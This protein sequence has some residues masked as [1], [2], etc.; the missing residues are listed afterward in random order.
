MKKRRLC[1]I[2]LICMMAGKI[3]AQQ[4]EKEYQINEVVISSLGIKKERKKIANAIQ[5]L[6][7]SELTEVKTVNPLDNLSGKVSGVQITA[8]TSGVASSSRIVI[9]G[10][11][12][13]NI[14]NNSP[15]FIID[16]I[17]ISNRI[18]GVGGSPTNQGDLPS[19][20]G[21]GI[22]DINPED[23]ESMS[24]LK[25]GAAALYGSRAAN[26]VIMITTK[27]GQ[28]GRKFAVNYNSSFMF[29]NP[30]L[31]E[32]Q[33]VYGQGGTNSA[34]E[35]F[36]LLNGLG[37]NYGPKFDP[38]LYLL[39][40]G[41]PEYADGVKIPFVR[42]YDLRDIFK[43]GT[44]IVNNISVQGTTDDISYRISYTNNQN[45]GYIPNTNL[46]KNTFST[47]STFKLTPKFDLSTSL[48]FVNTK[49]DN[50][51]V[52][53][54]GSQGL[55]YVLY[56]N[57]LN[58]DLKWAKNYW[59]EP[60]VKQN[61]SLGWADNPYLIANENINAFN[62]DRFFGS[63]QLDYKINQNFSA[64]IRTGLDYQ[65]E[66]R[67]SRRPMASHRYRKG[68]LRL[69][70]LNFNEVNVDML[71]KYQNKFGDFELDVLGGLSR[72]DRKLSEKF[73]QSN[74]LM[75]HGIYSLNNTQNFVSR[76]SEFTQ[77]RIN[78]VLGSINL[79]YKDYA[80]LE[81][82]ARNDWFSTLPTNKNTY[83]Y[84][85][86]SFSWLLN[87]SLNMG[88]A[89][90]LLKIRTN[91]AIIANGTSPE[92][93]QKKYLSGGLLGTVTNPTVAPNT[94][95]KPETTTTKEVGL[96]F[97]GFKNRLEFNASFYQNATKNQIIPVRIS[98]ATG[99]NANLVNAGLVENQGIEAFLRWTAVKSKNFMW[100]MSFNF[101][102]NRGWV[103]ELYKDLQSYIIAEGPADVTIEARP[104][105][106]M[107]DIYGY[108]FKR[109]NDGQII[110]NEGLPV[111]SDT[112]ERIGNY[113]P[114]FMLG[115]RNQFNYKNFSLG[116][117]FD[118]RK[119]GVIYSYTNAIGGESG[120]L[121]YTLEGRETG[122]I[123]K[124]VKLE[125]GTYVPNDVR[126]YPEKYYH[127]GGYYTR[128]NAESNSFDASFIK[129]R[130][131]SL[132]YSLPKEWIKSAGME[133]LHISLVGRNLLRWTK[134]PQHIDPESMAMS[135]GTLLPGMEVM[136]YPVAIGYGVN[137]NIKF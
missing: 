68:M 71:L 53:G 90:N 137:F 63:I 38:N 11:N 72:M 39:Q 128:N 82:T 117:L 79:G 21:S 109:T 13:L 18:F 33:S 14:N 134:T 30:I 17:P 81:V 110:F 65:N 41:S 87:K 131:V 85:S 106:R 98:D 112:K 29:Q 25:G 93:L 135:G 15:M 9:R 104:G 116:V 51:P 3:N 46:H 55:M 76:Y 89:I 121:P 91:W 70:D 16:G 27:K 84:P 78:S 74:A 107:G 31:P 102:R 73:L 24:V 115:F 129:L 62:R 101:T 5:A 120:V 124:G 133:E 69:Q 4:N 1:I 105:G 37:E 92:F 26:G 57:H 60:G 32:F 66:D 8:G 123:G 44:Q 23:I 61:Y 83:L 64:L 132:G 10:D 19:D 45:E 56:W 54:Y 67:T 99:Y 2:G 40:N 127:F 88:R 75:T 34:G 100:N 80:F 97:I 52:T 12:S 49:S 126:V 59:L 6:S 95:I 108:V 125:N 50:V 58:N 20:Y 114:D 103:R 130:E 22:M 43:T 48:N 35:R 28:K 7:G 122:I 113:N 86:A 47:H 94:D 119:G 42:R 111:L 118:I 96:E 36:Q 77:E 136:Q